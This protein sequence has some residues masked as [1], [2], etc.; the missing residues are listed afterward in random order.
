VADGRDSELTQP[1]GTAFGRP[2]DTA[3]APA[4][5]PTP[6]RPGDTALTVRP[7]VRR[8]GADWFAAWR[9][10]SARDWALRLLVVGAALVVLRAVQAAVAALSV[11]A[12]TAS[13]LEHPAPGLRMARLGELE[14]THTTGLVALTMVLIS[15]ALAAVLLPRSRALAAFAGIKAFALIAAGAIAVLFT[16]EPTGV[17]IAVAGCGAGIV[18]L[19]WPTAREAAIRVLA[20]FGMPHVRGRVGDLLLALKIAVLVALVLI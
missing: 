3:T 12:V 15:T 1:A 20:A 8:R 6:G 17:R 13:G 5:H 7:S 4:A 14:P 2:A 16:A 19:L 9:R 10:L 11:L 18:V